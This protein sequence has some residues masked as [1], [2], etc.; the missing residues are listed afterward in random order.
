MSSEGIVKFLKK[1][2]LLHFLFWVGFIASF[3]LGWLNGYHSLQYF[4]LNYV[5]VLLIYAALIYGT[6]YIV[7]GYLIQR[8]V[9]VA[10]ALFFVALLVAATHVSAVFYNISNPE[11]RT[12]NLLNY[13]PFYSFLAMF[14]LALKIARGAYLQLTDE[15]KQKEALLEQK[16]HF[17][18]AQI[19]PHFLFNTLNN[20][21]G[22]AIEKS[23]SL[24]EL[25]LR[26]SN[27]LRHQI[28]N[29][30]SAYIQLSIEL[31]Y[32]K[33]YME[34]E[35]IRHAEN[36]SFQFL[37]KSEIPDDVYIIPSVLIVF[38]ENAFKH[39]KNISTQLIEITGEV[40]LVDDELHFRLKNSYPDK[41]FPNHEKASGLGLKNVR[42]RLEML[43]A[44]NYALHTEQK[45]GYFE[46]QLRMKL[47]RA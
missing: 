24:P 10:A 19:H 39:S 31:A 13:L 47:K 12:I 26:L 35:R 30:E 40:E 23:D 42:S 9:Y 20:F 22:L 6:L 15:L 34:L 41:S 17:L 2:W 44:E 14:A 7:Y 18:R 45:D 46:V 43:G 27:I 16:E 21:Y 37:V 32:L 11:G 38:V 3:S 5:G 25:M 28:Y 36:L 29:S 1:R 8:K 33:D 4:L